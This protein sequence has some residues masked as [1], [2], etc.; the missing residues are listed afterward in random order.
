MGD[1]TSNKN[2]L[3]K[4]TGSRSTVSMDVLSFDNGSSD[5]KS[6]AEICS[7]QGILINRYYS[8]MRFA[9]KSLMPPIEDGLS[10][11]FSM[12]FYGTREKPKDDDHDEEALIKTM[13]GSTE[14]NANRQSKLVEQKYP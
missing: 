14:F 1:S 5:G 7:I 4:S 10:K 8:G 6:D 12:E 11:L 13:M 3:N 9:A 2:E